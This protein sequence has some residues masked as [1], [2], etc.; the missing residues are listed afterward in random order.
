MRRDHRRRLPLH[1]LALM[2]QPSRRPRDHPSHDPGPVTWREWAALGFA[3]LCIV[4]AC[5]AF[6]LV[7]PT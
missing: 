5:W 2:E 6:G 4:F 7:G 3:V 1:R